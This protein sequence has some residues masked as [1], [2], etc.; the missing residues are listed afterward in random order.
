MASDQICLS[1]PREMRHGSALSIMSLLMKSH[2][3][4]FQTT[5]EFSNLVI[6]KL[7]T[8]TVQDFKHGRERTHQFQQG[9]RDTGADCTRSHRTFS[10]GFV[11]AKTPRSD[12]CTFELLTEATRTNIRCY[13]TSRRRCRYGGCSRKAKGRWTC[14]QRPLSCEAQPALQAHTFPQR[15]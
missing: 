4:A 9:S 15:P 7:R 2:R 3:L 1:T 10:P 14:L 8:R 13:A 11:Q 5:G 6:P 12:R